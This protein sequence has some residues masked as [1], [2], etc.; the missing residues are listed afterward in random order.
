M[1]AG[2]GVAG[3]ALGVPEVF[4][5]F[6]MFVVVVWPP[7]VS[8]AALVVSAAAGITNVRGL[9]FASVTST[10]KYF[11]SPDVEV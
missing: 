9:S 11:T 6:V 2:A 4:T 3:A 10:G 5:V 8:A 7:D 1:V